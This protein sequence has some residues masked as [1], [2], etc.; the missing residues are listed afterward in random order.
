MDLALSADVQGR[1]EYLDGYHVRPGEG[2]Q[3][4]HVCEGNKNE[5]RGVLPCDSNMIVI[6]LRSHLRPSPRRLLCSSSCQ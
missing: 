3:T 1:G 5:E 2:G 6:S 4:L